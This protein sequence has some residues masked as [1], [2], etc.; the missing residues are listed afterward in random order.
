MPFDILFYTLKERVSGYFPKVETISIRDFPDWENPTWPVH[1]QGVYEINQA[2]EKK[3]ASTRFC[4]S[5]GFCQLH[6]VL[7]MWI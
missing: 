1:P 4:Q 3:R 5:I 6:T 2:L 7:C